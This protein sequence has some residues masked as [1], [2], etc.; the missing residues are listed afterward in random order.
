M[1]FLRDV[2]KI[3]KVRAC[4]T[5]LNYERKSRDGISMFGDCNPGWCEILTTFTNIIEI[6]AKENYGCSR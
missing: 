6:S 3:G 4:K 5:S 1:T 2:E